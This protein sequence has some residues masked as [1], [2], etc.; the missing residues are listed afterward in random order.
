MQTII[1][2]IIF[3][4]LRV[5]PVAIQEFTYDQRS[6]MQGSLMGGFELRFRIT[7]L[8]ADQSN[9]QI[10]VGEKQCLIQD[11]GPRDQQSSLGSIIRCT[12]TQTD[13]DKTLL[14]SLLEY[15]N[16]K[17]TTSVNSQIL[18]RVK[19]QGDTKHQTFA[20]SI[21]AT[22]ILYQVIGNIYPENQILFQYSIWAFDSQYNQFFIGQHICS[23][24][25]SLPFNNLIN[26]YCKV[27]QDIEAGYYNVTIKAPSGIQYSR[28]ESFQQNVITKQQYQVLVI[29]Y[30]NKLSS[31]LAS[32]NGQV[33]TIDGY[34][35][36]QFKERIQLQIG[37]Q[38]I[39]YEVIDANETQIKVFISN[40][41]SDNNQSKYLQS[42]GLQYTKYNL[43][44]NME[45]LNCSCLRQQIKD[46]ITELNKLKIIDSIG[47]PEQYQIQD[48]YYGEFYRGYFK[49]PFNGN[50]TFLLSSNDNVEFYLSQQ[51]GFENNQETLIAYN[52]QSTVN[53]RT[54]KQS[55]NSSSQV[56]SL[57]KGN[58]YYI[59]L[60]HYS[61]NIDS[62]ITLSVQ[63]E[64]DNSTILYQPIPNELLYIF[65][66]EPQINLQ[67]QGILAI[68]Q[69]CQYKL[70]KNNNFYLESFNINNLTL[71]LT[72]RQ[73]E[74]NVPL[75][76][77]QITITYSGAKCYLLNL[78]QQNNI[79]IV[80]CLLESQN[81]NII[82]EA[83]DNIPVVDIY[84]IG[85]INKG[86]AVQPIIQEIVVTK[87]TPS[88]GSRDGGT[89]LTIE[90]D[91]FPR[92]NQGVDFIIKIGGT[93]V[94]PLYLDN[95]RINL[96]TAPYQGDSTIEITFN[97]KTFS[98]DK[99]FQYEQQNQ[100][101]IYNLS[102]YNF[103]PIY[104]GFLT[105]FAR[106]LVYD[107]SILNV[108]LEN[109]DKTYIAPIVSI[110]NN[111]LKVYLRGGMPGNYSINIY[112]NG[113]EKSK[114]ENNQSNI[115]QYG[116][117][118]QDIQPSSG[119]LKGGTILKI[120]GLNFV[121]EESLVFIGK[122]VN[123]ICEIN[124]QVSNDTYI[125]C[126]TSSKPDISSYNNPVDV[127]VVTRASL[128]SICINLGGCKYQYTNES[129]PK[130]LSLPEGVEK[131]G[132][133]LLVQNNQENDQF[134]NNHQDNV[135]LKQ[136]LQAKHYR[137]LH[138]SKSNQTQR[139]LNQF[140]SYKYYQYG[141]EE[142]LSFLGEQIK[143]PKIILKG[144]IYNF[145]IDTQISENVITYEI[146]NIPQGDY[147]TYVQFDSGYADMQ[148]ISSIPLDLSE[149]DVDEISYGGQLITLTGSGFNL[150][151]GLTIKIQD[152]NC[153]NLQL[154]SNS[155][156]QCR[157]PLLNPDTSD[158]IIS[159]LDQQTNQILYGTPAQ[160]TI[161]KKSISM[162]SINQTNFLIK[163]QD[164]V[165]YIGDPSQIDLVIFG[166]KLIDLANQ[167]NPKVYLKSESLS[168]IFDGT[169][170][171]EMASNQISVQFKQIP[172]GRYILEYMNGPVYSN[173]TLKVY[174]QGN[175][176]L[177][178]L[179]S[180]QSLAG[181]QNIT[182]YGQGF[183]LNKQ[184]NKIF[185]CG[186]SCDILEVSSDKVI[187]ESPPLLTQS[188]IKQFPLQL[189]QFHIID[190]NE[191]ILSSTDGYLNSY[192]NNMLFDNQQSSCI[193][194]GVGK[195]SLIIEFQSAVLLELKNISFTIQNDTTIANNF[196]G[197]RIQY[198]LNGQDVW[199][200]YYVMDNK[201]KPGENSYQLLNTIQNIKKLR[202]YDELS[203]SRCNICELKIK[204]RLTQNIQN[205]YDQDTQ[206]GAQVI[207]NDFQF[208][209]IEN[210]TQYQLTQ[211]PFVESINTKYIPTDNGVNISITGSSFGND[212]SLITIQID[213]VNCII[214]ESNE[215]QINCT[216]GIK[217]LGT[218]KISGE[219]RVQINGNIAINKQ[220][221]YYGNLWSDINTWGGYVFPSDGDSV[222]VKQ[223]QII[224]VDMETPKLISIFIEGQLLFADNGKLNSLDAQ[225]LIIHQGSM[226]IGSQEQPYQSQARITLRGEFNDTQLTGFG[227]KVLG[228]YQ[229]NLQMFGK[230]KTPVWTLLNKTIEIG[231]NQLL[232]DQ[233]V[234][235]NI[236]DQIIIRD[237]NYYIYILQDKRLII[238]DSPFQYQH[239][240]KIEYYGD[241]WFH[242]KVEVGVLTRNI[243]IKGDQSKYQ[244]N[245][246]YNFKIYGDTS[247][248]TKIQISYTEFINGGQTNYQG[249]Y[250][251][252][253]KQNNDLTG[254]YL[255]G[256]S[257][258]NNNA[259]CIV[260]NQVQ[261][262]Q[263][264]NNICF[265]TKGHSIHLLSGLETNIRLIDN[266]IINT[267]SSNLLLQSDI[268][269]A[270]CLIANP[271]NIITGNRVAGSEYNG[272]LLDFTKNSDYLGN[273]DCR[274]GLNL[275]SFFNNSAHSSVYGLNIPKY[276]P[277]EEPC[278]QF[279]QQP[280]K[281]AK[282]WT[283]ERSNGLGYGLGVNGW[284]TF[285]TGWVWGDGRD[286]DW[287]LQEGDQYGR[288][289]DP[290]YA[291]SMKSFISSFKTWLNYQNGIQIYN[292]G[293]VELLNSQ[294]ADCKNT[295]I[296]VQQTDQSVEG[297]LINNTLI[298][299][300]S[301]NKKMIARSTGLILPRT[302]IYTIQNLVI[303]NYQISDTI[304]VIDNQTNKFTRN[305][306]VNYKLIGIKIANS[307]SKIVDETF[308][309]VIF[310]DLDGTLTNSTPSYII[311]SKHYLLGI[312][313]CERQSSSKWDNIMFCKMDKV[314]IRDI[315]FIRTD[316]PFAI[317]R[318]IQKELSLFQ[319]PISYDTNDLILA[320]G[321]T[322]DLHFPNYKDI[323]KSE[324]NLLMQ[325]SNYDTNINKG[326]IFR[327]DT[328]Q[329]IGYTSIGGPHLA[330]FYFM[331]TYL[332]ANFYYTPARIEPDPEF[333]EKTC[334]LGQYK[335]D[336]YTNI[337]ESCVKQKASKS[338]DQFINLKSF[339]IQGQVQSL[340][341]P[342]DPTPTPTPTPIPIPI[343]IPI[344]TPTPDPI[345]TPTPD[346]IPEP[347][348]DPTP[349]PPPP[350]PVYYK[351]VW[352][353][354]DAWESKKLPIQDEVVTIRFNY[355]I[356]LDID[357]PQLK[358]LIIIG[359]LI[360]DDQRDTSILKANNLWIKGGKLL[361]GNSTYPFKGKI[362]IQINSQNFDTDN[363]QLVIQG[364]VNLFGVPPVTQ[365]TR[366]AQFAQKGSETITVDS[367]SNW[368]VGD[369]IIIGPSGSDPK[370]SEEFTIKE[371]QENS[372]KLSGKLQYNHFGDTKQTL[373]QQGIG[374]LDMRA[375]IG[376][377]TRNIQIGTGEQSTP[378]KISFRQN[379]QNPNQGQFI[380][381]GVEV[382]YSTLKS[383]DQ[384]PLLDIQSN[385]VIIDGCTFHHSSGQF[386]KAQNTYSITIKN[387]VF[388]SG[389]GTLVQLNNI[390]NLI[391]TNN[392]LMN[393]KQP[394]ALFA[395]F[396]YD[397]NTEIQSDNLL[398]SD[399]VGQGSED[400]GFLL[401]TTSCQNSN[402]SSFVNNQCSS[403]NYVCFSFKQSDGNCD[404]IASSFAYHSQTGI[405]ASLQTKQ[406]KISQLILVEN[407]INLII[408]MG[409]EEIKNNQLQISNSFISAYLRPSCSLCHS[410][411]LLPYCK[412]TIGIQIPTVTTKANPPSI[413]QFSRVR[414]INN[415][416]GN[417]CQ[418]LY[419]FTHF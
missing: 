329:Q 90:G 78:T 382:S 217:D 186:L 1:K 387:T 190:K 98:S 208:P 119:S 150:N 42:S 326:I 144:A 36:T 192:L 261:N 111:E 238:V 415:Y 37:G 53:F 346:P 84:P 77:N 118:I 408:K 265:N 159:Q 292:I 397:D 95:N 321:F 279:M 230:P 91:C 327:F 308:T 85:V 130:L 2:V 331:G 216:S 57:I 347:T 244:N 355:D 395:N 295:S 407:E 288:Y 280:Q 10:Y 374:N 167:N 14:P 202:I 236:G 298:I 121:I 319:D 62:N 313:G 33:L 132:S 191:L 107:K 305:T 138:Q 262:L 128:E 54:Y 278:I 89:Y 102:N 136:D 392:L 142:T 99:L 263:I 353:N 287:G 205:N 201:I 266:L 22:P 340:R 306:A 30:I 352:S 125:E 221:V 418:I 323:Y 401:M 200:D 8:D 318:S 195:Q 336:E 129:T 303:Y 404:Y 349:E 233:M 410:N 419:I 113:Q 229:C 143:P 83:G 29:P 71:Q 189:K 325:N 38:N 416:R 47:V 151:K 23:L 257:I 72:I 73:E 213:N 179:V 124:E 379:L 3:F 7:G 172:Y 156:V 215:S 19:G 148:W 96:A 157:T 180:N 358:Q 337:F 46:N 360:F 80:N 380:L 103:S 293:N 398:V 338:F 81:G 402:R 267:Q 406:I 25:Q 161:R 411:D 273:Q 301:S 243:Q 254:S 183:D 204:G 168:T 182:I 377:L 11:D 371:I 214:Q 170:I 399:N 153:L 366:L 166:D 357:P 290:I 63:I 299:K 289:P 158:L 40:Y 351:M 97:N 100:I 104:K 51:E 224:I 372:I 152:Q 274:A 253:F 235:W 87:V 176:K 218:N 56:Q 237:Q 284:N 394:N 378:F 373:N 69:T 207:V 112:K 228:C 17:I 131:L 363:Q 314:E 386:I 393:A 109:Q 249:R 234:D 123:Q 44:D 231:D 268:S 342:P 223:G 34:G 82:C 341:P 4:S 187:C 354:P 126:L 364:L 16:K 240:S 241:Q 285:K 361:A 61:N 317:K 400:S 309:K 160:I 256:N 178:A 320:T 275:T 139:Q 365:W 20:Q 49:A 154:I 177:Q 385:G 127:A 269:P 101:E 35:F 359:S 145:V 297:S 316:G 149:V 405:L 122:G 252:Y 294:L 381:V 375:A 368:N 146:P 376:H 255:V 116:A 199:K 345:P 212:S 9:N 304:F 291:K 197:T 92:K 173:T 164:R 239:Y 272:F 64:Y 335:Y 135:L 226:I 43:S 330:T 60:Y 339:M 196:I 21:A 45:I 206:C 162:I 259:R 169:I 28:P 300:S 141:Y 6:Q 203:K 24:N 175:I 65:T 296:Y 163:Y 246:G 185:L 184:N 414:L 58:Y 302:Q 232:L 286:F 369:L 350:G 41:T 181:G 245:Y 348:P 281:Y 198:Q 328:K 220:I 322:Y 137:I 270:G 209:I 70:A 32:T 324:I 194:L 412:S 312:D 39:I 310:W 93:I 332:Q 68:C 134:Q 79:S 76:L 391:F 59:E 389:Q 75:Q 115:F 105:I 48:S 264:Q 417:R 250:P 333:T 277:Q 260:L 12:T 52:N 108:T 18:I 27:P 66:D 311:P 188:I 370:Q 384:S 388:Y 413:T 120:I 26:Y 211:T 282:K 114:T 140:T 86:S 193:Y 117:F 344:P 396:I 356:T 94:Y 210:V 106:N 219:F 165:N 74:S 276:T 50:Y 409:T 55:L 247:Q 251:I 222:I 315:T 88:V 390:R 403:T 13:I 171:G 5:K 174:V 133:R 15:P 110:Q 307:T 227:N 334:F 67:V 155:K 242:N 271:Q 147:Q 31:N 383:Y 362:K 248:N 225:Y 367:S 343:P 283:T 258:Y